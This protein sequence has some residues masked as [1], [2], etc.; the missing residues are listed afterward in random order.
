MKHLKHVSTFVLGT[1]IRLS[2]SALALA[3]LLAACHDSA[4]PAAPE[5]T[6]GNPLDARRGSSTQ[7]LPTGQLGIRTATVDRTFAKVQYH[8]GPVMTGAVNIYFIWYGSW[9]GSTAPDLLI[10]FATRIGSSSYHA[11]NTLYP[12]GTGARP[13]NSVT[14][15]GSIEDPYSFGASLNR[16]DVDS[17]VMRAIED[18]QVPL[19]PSGI[20]FVL[21]AADVTVGYESCRVYC[22]I[23]GYT[24]VDGTPIK[25]AFV[26]NPERC[27]TQCAAQ[28][29][30]PNGTLAGDAMASTVAGLIS[31][32]VTDPELSSWYDRLGL[33]NA[34]KCAWD[35][36][37]TYTA[38]NGAQANISLGG[39]DYLLQRNWVPTRKGGYCA[40]AAPPA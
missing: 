35:F 4:P 24:V 33:E 14:F 29:V 23:H 3:A 26:G 5:G 12:D 27:P 19:D 2:C 11:I 13:V 32:A 18:V 9:T 31:A 15:G 1:Q 37:P 36:G 30:G 16:A 28:A 17:I 6:P 22:G 34:G 8:S 39:R 20:Y 7:G 10:E 38:A 40:L 25:L 21:G